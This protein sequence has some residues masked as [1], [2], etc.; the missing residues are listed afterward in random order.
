VIDEL[1]YTA[2][3]ELRDGTAVT[4]RTIRKND[5]AG[6]LTAFEHLDQESVYTRFFTYKRELTEMDLHELTE[7]NPKRVVA[8]SSATADLFA[9]RYWLNRQQ[10]SVSPNAVPLE[11]FAP[12]T[13][14]EKAGSRAE[15]GLP[16]DSPVIAYVG[17]LVAEKGV[18]IAIEALRA[19][20]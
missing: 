14:A 18:D 19:V 6:L 9:R 17:A 16:L 2:A 20:V 3:D 5:R 11:H 7:V 12:A 10:V 13:T 4:I 1:N 15:F 8:L